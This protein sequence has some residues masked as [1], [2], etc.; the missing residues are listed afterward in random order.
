LDAI[1]ALLPQKQYYCDFLQ[2]AREP[3]PTGG[4]VLPGFETWISEV[5]FDGEFGNVE[6][7]VIEG[8]VN[9]HDVAPELTF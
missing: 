2:H 9:A 7:A 3:I 8:T 4:R 5:Y 1:Y 6:Q